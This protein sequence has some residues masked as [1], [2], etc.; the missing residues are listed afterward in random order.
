MKLSGNSGEGVL[1]HA[2]EGKQ[3][4]EVPPIW[5][6]LQQEQGKFRSS[7]HK[8]SRERATGPRNFEN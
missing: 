7:P 2:N 8:N 5:N 4:P 6:N 1:Q 3:L